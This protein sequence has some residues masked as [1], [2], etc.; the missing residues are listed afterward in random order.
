MLELCCNVYEVDLPPGC[1]PNYRLLTESLLLA[2][3]AAKVLANV[4]RPDSENIL[5]Q[6]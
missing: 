4:L 6:L 2:G 1:K 3:A 5:T